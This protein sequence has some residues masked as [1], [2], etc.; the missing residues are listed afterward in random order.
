[1]QYLLLLTYRPEDN[2]PEGTPEFEAERAKRASSVEFIHGD[3]LN[4][5][6][7]ERVGV[8]DVVFCNGVIYHHPSPFEILDV[9]RKICAQTLILGSATIPEIPG[10]RQAAVYYPFLDEKD[11][12]LW[13]VPAR[14]FQEGL[15]NPFSR[16]AGYSNFFWG[17][18]P[19]CVAGLLRSARF[20]VRSQSAAPFGTLFVCSPTET[21]DAQ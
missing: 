17:M 14:G 11:R 10:L 19:S 5:E 1:M 7:I 9:L 20:R 21:A 3:I 16:D 6:V 2:T 15:S 12:K 18:T 4:P 8:V 13:T